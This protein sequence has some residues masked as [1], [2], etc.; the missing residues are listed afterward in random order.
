MLSESRGSV[1][2]RTHMGDDRRLLSENRVSISTE[3]HASLLAL[4]R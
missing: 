3:K 2:D 4:L 1:C